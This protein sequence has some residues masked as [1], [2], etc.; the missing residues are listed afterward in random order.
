MSLKQSSEK[1]WKKINEEHIRTHVTPVYRYFSKP[2]YADQFCEGKIMIS[3]LQACREYED[4]EQGDIYE[5]T[6]TLHLKKLTNKDPSWRH[7]AARAGI[8][9]VGNIKN[10]FID[11]VVTR[12]TMHH[13]H[14][15]CTT[16]APDH[17]KFAKNF[18][19]Y[20]VEISHVEKFYYLLGKTLWDQGFTFIGRGKVIYGK[21]EFDQYGNPLGVL[22][23]VKRPKYSWQDEYRMMWRKR[24]DGPI[25]PTL[26]NCPEVAHLCKRIK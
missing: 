18:G 17:E 26:Y 15:L 4:E 7:H 19:Q 14:V 10:V 2:E 12:T 9:L 1:K 6:E 20:C 25:K 23:S 3:T 8:G 11:D 24:D 21:I 13:A 22:G 5:A 16:N